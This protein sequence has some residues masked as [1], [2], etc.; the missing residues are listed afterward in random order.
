MNY[1][2]V[3]CILHITLTAWK[4]RVYVE[5]YCFVLNFVVTARLTINIRTLEYVG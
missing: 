4:R 5:I 3:A 2:Y 1:V